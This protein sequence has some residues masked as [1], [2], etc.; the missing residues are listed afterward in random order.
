MNK[1]AENLD[2]YTCYYKYSKR[3]FAPNSLKT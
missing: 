1:G 3:V 2:S